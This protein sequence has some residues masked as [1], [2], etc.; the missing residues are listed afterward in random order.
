MTIFNLGTFDAE[1]AKALIYGIGKGLA[2]TGVKTGY[3]TSV[4]T[5]V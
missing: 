1:G 3:D 5:S 4:E 2:Y